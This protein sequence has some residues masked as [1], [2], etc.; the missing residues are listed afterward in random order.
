M[1]QQTVTGYQ[2]VYFLLWAGSATVCGTDTSH[3]AE[4]MPQKS[5]FA[6]FGLYI[7]SYKLDS[8]QI[9]LLGN[10]QKQ[11]IFFHPS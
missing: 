10:F 6:C 5:P 11:C 4:W 3:T 7:L 2:L 9:T 8:T 1:L